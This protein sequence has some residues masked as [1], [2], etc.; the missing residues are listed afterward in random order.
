MDD[1][2]LLKHLADRFQEHRGRL[3]AVAY[4]MLGSLSEADDAVQEVWLKLGR[5]DVGEIRN[6]ASW[7]TT[8]VGRVCL[9]L[10][11][12]RAARREEPLDTYVPDPLVSPLERIDPEQEVLLADSVGLALLV[13]LETLEPAERL[14]FVLH[15][16]FAVPFDDIAPVVGR[17]SAATRQL[18]SRA[19]RRVR[20]AAA[21]EPELD[22]ARQKLVLD[23]FLAASR[24]GDFEALVSVLHPDV[25]LRVDSGV[26]VGGAA[27]S[28]VVHGATG[29]AQQALMFRQ[30]AEFSRLALVNGAVGVVTAPEGRPLSVMG[31][32]ITDGRVVE[33]YILA[34]PAR[35]S[36]LA[37]P[38]LPG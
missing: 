10:L 35:L 36:D 31:V 15:D 38:D 29:V 21:P 22:P 27:A 16:M 32:T 11:R 13:V 9:D 37:L 3:R 7:L 18:A 12:T 34:D 25:V 28:K 14:A 17:S 30:F 2:E 8:V 4:R 24:A 33:M 26:L 20:G 5:T 6:L 19:R 1:D 23:A